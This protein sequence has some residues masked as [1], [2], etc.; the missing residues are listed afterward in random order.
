MSMCLPCPC[1]PLPVSTFLA[2]LM[3]FADTFCNATGSKK[4]HHICLHPSHS[5][6]FLH[7]DLL[8]CCSAAASAKKGHNWVERVT[9]PVMFGLKELVPTLVKFGSAMTVGFVGCLRC[10]QTNEI[11]RTV[12]IRCSMQISRSCSSNANENLGGGSGLGE[13]S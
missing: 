11:A 12:Y 13:L 10:T 2:P 8:A 1:L 4:A 3:P 5:H 7:F 6:S 9:A